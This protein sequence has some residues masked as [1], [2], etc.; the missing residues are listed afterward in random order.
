MKNFKKKNSNHIMKEFPENH[1]LDCKSLINLCLD[2]YSIRF[3]DEVSYYSR[4]SI[5]FIYDFC[6]HYNPKIVNN[7]F[8]K[9]LTELFKDKLIQCVYCPTVKAYVVMLSSN[10]INLETIKFRGS[11][12][13]NNTYILNNMYVN[14]NKNYFD[15]NGISFNCL[16]GLVD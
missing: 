16:T 7:E 10:G 1:P 6:K 4:R 8:K 15:K 3:I 5:G 14:I 11:Q 12:L 13:Y 2:G 9:A